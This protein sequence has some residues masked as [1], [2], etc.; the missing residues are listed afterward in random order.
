MVVG[1]VITLFLLFV[2]SRDMFMVISAVTRAYSAW[3]EWEEFHR[4][5][6]LMEDMFL[7]MTMKGGPFIRTNDPHYYPYVIAD[8]MVRI[9]A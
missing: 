8:A 4:L 2:G 9:A 7:R 3:S 1:P 6:C 5:K